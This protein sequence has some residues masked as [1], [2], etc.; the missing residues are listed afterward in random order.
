[1]LVHE[2][3]DK[4]LDIFHSIVPDLTFIGRQSILILSSCICVPQLSSIFY[5]TYIV[6]HSTYVHKTYELRVKP[7]K[8]IEICDI[9]W[10]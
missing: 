2:N 10:V 7:S 1:M 3:I 5:Y 9:L 8:A 4:A 6:V